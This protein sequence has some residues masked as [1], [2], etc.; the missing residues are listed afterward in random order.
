MKSERHNDEL[1]KFGKHLK[2]LRETKC[3]SQEEL[4]NEADLS[5]SQISRIERGIIS[6]SLSQLISIS[7]ALKIDLTELVDF[8]IIDT[9]S[10]K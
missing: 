2:L 5:I 4:A 1:S 8:K 9:I 6:T 3:F 7:K 10:S